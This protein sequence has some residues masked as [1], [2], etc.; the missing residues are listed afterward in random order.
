MKSRLARIRVLHRLNAL[1]P[2]AALLTLVGITF[3]PSLA[4]SQVDRV[5]IDAR[6]REVEQH[7]LQTPFRLGDW[8]GTDEPLPAA[9]LEILHASAVLSRQYTNL[10]TGQRARLAIVYCGDARDML[11][12][13]PPVCYPRSGWRSVVQPASGGASTL[14]LPEVGQGVSANLYRFEKADPSGLERR[15][16]IVGFF[17]I[18]GVGMTSDE[19][20]LRDQSGSRAHASLGVGQVQVL[21]DGHPNPESV[22]EIAQEILRALPRSTFSIL[23]EDPA[24]TATLSMRAAVFEM[25][26]FGVAGGSAGRCWMTSNPA[27]VHGLFARSG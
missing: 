9:A 2:I 3:L 24:D 14:A 5:A 10:R 25:T 18:P 7:L 13:H 4:G 26:V 16:T 22:Q 20:V 11:G 8:V 6:V 15:I 19:K 12:H 17:A 21:L 27:S 23:L 1:A